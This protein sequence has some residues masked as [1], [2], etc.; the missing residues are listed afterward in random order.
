MEIGFVKVEID[1]V[2]KE[3]DSVGAEINFVCV[4]IGFVREEIDFVSKEINSVG[5]EINIVW[6]EIGFV[7]KEIATFNKEINFAVMKY[8]L[9]KQKALVED[10]EIEWENTGNGVWRKIMSYDDN[11]MLV[12]VK[13]IAGAV[14]ALHHHPHLQI[15]Y[16][17][18]GE[19]EVTMGSQVK[20][21]KA[22]DVYFAAPDIEHGVV[23]LKDGLLI[24]VFS[25]MREDFL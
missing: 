3:I 13:F 17:A 2:G 16:I 4:E 20:T 19:F 1:F 8:N 24:D 7:S 22:G 11:I 18:E 14:G 15:S 9:V 10:N 12:K 23:C 5:T 21:L 25:P 6:A